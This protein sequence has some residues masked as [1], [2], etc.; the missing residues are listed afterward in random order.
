MYITHTLLCGKDDSA[1]AHVR[2]EFRRYQRTVH[3]RDI[4]QVEYLLRR[5][6]NQLEVFRGADV[7][8]VSVWRPSA[9]SGTTE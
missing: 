4:E 1:M 3:V 6:K 2:D 8:R 9:S 7:T 5:A